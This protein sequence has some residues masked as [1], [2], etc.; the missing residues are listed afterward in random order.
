MSLNCRE[1]KNKSKG[2]KV[3][4]LYLATIVALIFIG[5]QLFFITKYPKLNNLEHIILQIILISI[6]FLE[7]VIFVFSSLII[8][9]QCFNEN[10]I[11]NSDSLHICLYCICPSAPFVFYLFAGKLIKKF[12]KYLQTYS[13]FSATIIILIAIY[14]WFFYLFRCRKA[15]I[16]IG[17]DKYLLY[18]KAA[19]SMLIAILIF[20]SATLFIDSFTSS[21]ISKITIYFSEK[22]NIVISR[23]LPEK[24]NIFKLGYQVFN[25][26]VNAMYPLLDM[27]AYVR[28]KINEFDKREKEKQEKREQLI[29]EKRELLEREKREELEKQKQEKEKREELEKE[30]QEKEKEK[31]KYDF[32]NYD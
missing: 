21:T 14:F 10:K 27:Y 32:Y 6:V 8:K 22:Y 7:L 20:S 13:S 19:K 12:P 3:I 15:I 29:K 31:Y 23:L 16:E 9:K 28:S 5:I 1:K 26:F 18:S 11:F 25:I 4:Y 2:I 30:K 17:S 24:Q